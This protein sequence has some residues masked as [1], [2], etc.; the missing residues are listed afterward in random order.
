[1]RGITAA[2]AQLAAFRKELSGDKLTATLELFLHAATNG[3][4]TAVHHLV[5]GY[6]IS[7][8]NMMRQHTEAVAM[9][10]LCLD[11]SSGV[12]ERYSADRRN[13]PVHQ[14]PTALRNRKRRA[15]LKALIG[16]DAEAWETILHLAEIHDQLSHAS[17]LS[18]AHNLYL[19]TEN[20]MILGS[21]YDPA[22]VDA[23]E[24]DLRR[25]A[26]A[27]E[28]LAHLIGVMIVA[29]KPKHGAA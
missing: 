28:S 20:G 1:M 22:K 7:A 15:A 18:L 23:Y 14:A 25:Y 16:F 2:L 3:V 27:A 21:E 11:S 17:A 13:Y 29:L 19:A 9:S 5:S 10:L 6:P 24:K 8:G 26:S 12:L 4:L